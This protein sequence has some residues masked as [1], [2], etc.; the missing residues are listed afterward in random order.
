[1]DEAVKVRAGV[2]ETVEVRVGVDEAVEVR[3]G[4]NEAMQLFNNLST[5]FK[6]EF[7]GMCLKGSEWFQ[8]AYPVKSLSH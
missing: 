6:N 1:M 5:I 8:Q 3:A 7:L 4:V 2:A